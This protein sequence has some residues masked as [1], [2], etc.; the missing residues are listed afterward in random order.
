MIKRLCIFT[1]SYSP[2]K[3]AMIDYLEKIIPEQTEVFLFVSNTN[4]NYFKTK[5]IK[6]VQTSKS[7]LLSLL[8]LRSFCRK[9]KIQRIINIGL[10][11]YEGFVMAHASLL[12]KTPFFCYHLGN[13]IDSFRAV[14][15][16][17]KPRIIFDILSS[18]ILSLFTKRI[19]LCTERQVKIAKKFLPFSKNKIFYLPTTIPTSFFKQKNKLLCRKKLKL[20][21]N[22]KIVI[23][24][25]RIGYLKGSDIIE[26]L[27]KL[28]PDKKFVLVGNIVDGTIDKKGYKNL[29]LVPSKTHEELVDYYNASDLCLF[30]SRVEGLP[31][32]PRE[33]MSCGI[34]CLVSDI[35]GNQM[36]IPVIK[37]SL[38]SKEMNEKLNYFFNLSEKE[39]K[40]LSKQSKNFIADNFENKIW[41]ERYL[42]IL[43]D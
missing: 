16:K 29:I 5:K 9:N 19:L 26:D 25:G 23:Y 24:V 14:S 30:P 41:K 2:N 12:T 43:F 36:L 17:Q 37:S 8:E 13:P 42:K 10:L 33:A 18:S 3:Q 11:P 38:N 21:E 6:L 35:P 28:N 7:K 40:S 1:S 34:P 39:K 22:E 27:V 32:V 20:K 4:K 15:L 31:L